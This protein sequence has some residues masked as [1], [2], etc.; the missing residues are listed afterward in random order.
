MMGFKYKGTLFC[1]QVFDSSPFSV[2]LH[3]PDA[4]LTCVA[5]AP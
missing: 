1:V 5:P 4:G 3:G 2:P